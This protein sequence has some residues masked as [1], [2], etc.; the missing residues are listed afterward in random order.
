MQVADD[1]ADGFVGE[2]DIIGCER[3]WVKSGKSGAK[4]RKKKKK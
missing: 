3:H 2:E 4:D 1:S